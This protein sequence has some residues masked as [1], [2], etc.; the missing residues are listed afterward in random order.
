[1][2]HFENERLKVEVLSISHLVGSSL[3]AGCLN[4]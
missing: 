3:Q 2:G 1:M 4:M